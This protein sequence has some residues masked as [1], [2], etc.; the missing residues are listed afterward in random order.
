MMPGVKRKIVCRITYTLYIHI[1][2]Y[3][4]ISNHTDT[5]GSLV[6]IPAVGRRENEL[7]ADLLF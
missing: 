7:R 2:I 4:Y 6:Y 3:M 1:Y 5:S